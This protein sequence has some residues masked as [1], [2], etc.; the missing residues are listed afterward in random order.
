[1]QEGIH[2]DTTELVC[3]VCS[4]FV[5]LEFCKPLLV[6]SNS[7]VLNSRYP[8]FLAMRRPDARTSMEHRGYP[9]SVISRQAAIPYATS[10]APFRG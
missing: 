1:M 9:H 2:V 6:K 5:Q 8:P 7:S 3:K 4:V 10:L